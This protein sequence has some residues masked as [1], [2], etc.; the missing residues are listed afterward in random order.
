MKLK[1]LV[2]L[3]CALWFAL[4]NA[5]ELPAFYVVDMRHTGDAILHSSSQYVAS[6]SGVPFVVL[7]T[8]EAQC[9]F[10]P[11]RR[12]GQRN[13]HVRIDEDAPP[14]SSEEGDDTFQS[15]GFVNRALAGGQKGQIA[16]GLE[17]MSNVRARRRGGYEIAIKGKRKVFVRHCLGTEG[18][19]FRLF[20][21]LHDKK[22][23]ATYYF[24]LGYP[25][26]PDCR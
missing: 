9:C 25:V 23:Y 6:R 22:P 16:F 19:N 1:Y 14:L 21:S 20:H 11:G 10:S 2:S 15:I 17:G 3:A 4:A 13:P 18:V 26:K 24:A 8:R 5:A 12:P 7:H